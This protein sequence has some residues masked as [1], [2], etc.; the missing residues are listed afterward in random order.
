M[1]VN[2]LIPKKQ[3]P[4]ELLGFLTAALVPLTIQGKHLKRHSLTYLHLN[5]KLRHPENCC[6]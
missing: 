2:F 6:P 4:G 3:K 1:A 5:I